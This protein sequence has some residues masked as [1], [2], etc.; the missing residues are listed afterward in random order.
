MYVPV[1]EDK[2]TAVP[3]GQGLSTLGLLQNVLI[4]QVDRLTHRHL[5]QL[6][7]MIRDSTATSQVLEHWGERSS[8]SITVAECKKSSGGARLQ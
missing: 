5:G 8:S 3:S 1:L 7:G 4:E 2:L 6:S